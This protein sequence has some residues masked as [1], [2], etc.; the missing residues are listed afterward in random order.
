MLTT[1]SNLLLIAALVVT[2]P[3]LA[4]GG[5]ASGSDLRRAGRGEPETLAEVSGLAVRPVAGR[6]VRTFDPPATRF[7]A[8]HRG[9]DL[10]ASEGEPVVAAMGGTVT[11]AGMVARRSWVT[12]DHGG[13]L[14]T[15]YGPIRPRL[16]RAGDVVAPG[17]W[18]GFIARGATR[19][20]WGARLDGEYIDPMSLLGGWETY[21]TRADDMPELP[22]LGGLAAAVDGG[23]VKRGGLRW[24]AQGPTTSRFGMRVHPIT[25]QRRQHTGLDIGAPASAPV[26]AAGGGTVSVAGVLGGLGKAVTIDH[27][28]GVSTLYAHQSSLAVR[29][30]Q[31][32]AAGAVIG[33]VGSSGLSTGPHL[34]F[35]VRVNGDARDPLGWLRR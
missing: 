16:V 31:R 29:T 19:L 1:T 33:R 7:G 4:V 34:H 3:F 18:I 24:P 2:V 21:L 22:A 12:V 10:R 32:V 27:G 28:D 17:E 9:V 6:V 25:G 11:F 13:G 14:N 15:T 35:E 20:D 5:T 8:G 23:V 26:R 30:G